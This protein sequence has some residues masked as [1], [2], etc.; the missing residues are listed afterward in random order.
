MS[1]VLS[2]TQT[3]ALYSSSMGTQTGGAGEL[4]PRCR[5][6]GIPAGGTLRR[7]VALSDASSDARRVKNEFRVSSAPDERDAIELLRSRSDVHG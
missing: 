7:P 3:G 4:D 1:R 2:G 6:P 5:I